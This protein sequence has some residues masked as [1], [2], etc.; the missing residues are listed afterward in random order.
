MLYF[1]TATKEDYRYWLCNAFRL[2]TQMGLHKNDLSKN[3][4]EPTRKLF[5][6]IWWVLYIR[7]S[8]VTLS[9]HDNVR[10][11]HDSDFDTT[12]LTEDDWPVEIIPAQLEHIIPPSVPLQKIF[13][14]QNCKLSRICKFGNRFIRP[15]YS[16]S[17]RC[18]VPSGFRIIGTDTTGRSRKVSR[19]YDF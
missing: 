5:R 3:I 18:K 19:G 6:R 14:V 12:E 16:I 11:I 9:G 8:V 4:D 10:K 15:I 13:V 7:D 2:A 1:S 17:I